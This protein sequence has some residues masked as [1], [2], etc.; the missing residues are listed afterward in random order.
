MDRKP[1]Q[2]VKE[3]GDMIKFGTAEDESSS[4]VLSFLEFFIEVFWRTSK[5]SI[6]VIHHTEQM[7][8]EGFW[9]QH[10]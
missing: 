10:Q 3:R 5:Q 9:W 8:T 7:H 1:K 6:T 4:M 2:T